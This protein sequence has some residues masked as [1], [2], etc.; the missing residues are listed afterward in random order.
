MAEM[1]GEEKVHRI[2]RVGSAYCQVSARTDDEAHNVGNSHQ[3]QSTESGDEGDNDMSAIR[4]S[5]GNSV[6]HLLRVCCNEFEYVGNDRR[7]PFVYCVL[8]I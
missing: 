5:F 6:D 3:D 4:N 2:L 7:R 1:N 8:S